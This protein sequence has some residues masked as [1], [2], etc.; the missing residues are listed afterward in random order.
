MIEAKSIESIE[1]YAAD[2]REEGIRM[3]GRA[4]KFLVIGWIFLAL[5]LGALF[6]DAPRAA[7]MLLLIAF[8]VDKQSDRL[9]HHYDMINLHWRLAIFANNEANRVIRELQAKTN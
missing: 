1:G 7:V 6:S 4:T 8:C 5:G 9:A 2:A 3:A